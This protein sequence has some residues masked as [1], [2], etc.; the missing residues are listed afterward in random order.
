MASDED[1]ATIAGVEPE[2]GIAG[3]TAAREPLSDPTG[4]AAELAAPERPVSVSRFSRFK[5]VR[6]SAACW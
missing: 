5:S 4:I 1:A 6:M 3:A 2:D